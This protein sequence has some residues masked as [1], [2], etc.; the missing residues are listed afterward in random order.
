MRKILLTK[1]LAGKNLALLNMPD[2]VTVNVDESDVKAFN[3]EIKDAEAVLLSTAFKVTEE[4]M[5][6]AKNLKVI[7]R[8]GVG[9]D[10]VDV[11]AATKRGILV[12]NTPEAN[13]LS[14]AEHTVTLIAC[15][16]KQILLYD[17]ELRKGNFK[18]RRSNLSVDLEGKTLGLIGCGRIG[19]M[20]AKKCAAAFDMKTIGYDPFI[21]SDIDGI[22]IY[23]DIE[24]VFKTA[25]YITLHMPL[26]DETKNMVD[27]KF[28][29][30]MKPT[31]YIVNTARGGLVDEKALAQVLKEKKIAGA[32]FDVFSEEPP[33]ADHPFLE[34]DNMIL[35]PHSAALTVECTERMSYDAALGISDYLKGNKPKFVYNKELISEGKL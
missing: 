33:A 27:A 17:K 16:S 12:L 30:L 14:V 29:S 11:K 10:N 19:R 31:A 6:T 9:V 28:L 13:S 2:V 21:S 20:V 23:R 26:T 25:D 32:A 34:L 24:E 1:K 8:T 3:E 4:V 7:S 22:K 35:T 5:E 15:I 18:I